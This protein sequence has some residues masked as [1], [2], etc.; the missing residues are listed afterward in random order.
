MGRENQSCVYFEW[1]VL[2]G[3]WM[4]FAWSEKIFLRLF[5]FFFRGLVWLGGVFGGSVDGSS[6]QDKCLLGLWGK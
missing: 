1:S 2:F 6:G 4:L 3:S 5:F